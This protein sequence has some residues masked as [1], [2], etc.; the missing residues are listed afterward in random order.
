MWNQPEEYFIE[1][2]SNASME[3]FPDNTLSKFSNK[4][5]IPLE[6]DGEWVVGIQEIFYPIDLEP[7]ERKIQVQLF[8]SD[9]T[10]KLISDVS[11]NENDS[12]E[13]IV[14]K[15]NEA[16]HALFQKVT[17]DVVDHT[18][19]RDKRSIDK[20][21][22]RA[23]SKPTLPDGPLKN[24]LT[25]AE[26]NAITPEIMRNMEKAERLDLYDRISV[27]VPIIVDKLY[28][29]MEKYRAE[30]A[31]K[32]TEIAALHDN[33]QTFTSQ[34]DAVKTSKNEEHQKYKALKNDYDKKINDLNALN[35]N[36]NNLK[37]KITKLE[38][39]LQLKENE[40]QQ[41]K[42][43]ATAV[44]NKFTAKEKELLEAKYSFSQITQVQ[45]KRI[46]DLEESLQK[47]KNE[48]D[49]NMNTISGRHNTQVQ[50][51]QTEIDSL[52]NEKIKTDNENRV[53]IKKISDEF[54]ALQIAKNLVI[55][56]L[57]ETQ[58]EHEI[59]KMD[60]QRQLDDL[61][62]ETK[63]LKDEKAHLE[64]H[65]HL[66]SAEIED[67]KH[68]IQSLK[69]KEIDLASRLT[70]KELEI[71]R[72][73][74]EREDEKA[75]IESTRLALENKE[76][77]LVKRLTDLGIK[78]AK[79][80]T[81]NDNTNEFLNMPGLAYDNGKIIFYPGRSQGK[82]YIPYFSD[83]GFLNALGFDA[84]SY[85]QMISEF[86]AGK[87]SFSSNKRCNL[88]LRSHLMFINSDIVAEHFVG[89]KSARVMR[90]LPIKRAK[91]YEL[92][93]EKFLKPFYYPVRSNRIEDI[94]FLLTDEMGQNI[95]FN[96][97]RVLIGLHLKH[98]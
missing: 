58:R 25:L 11:L 51:M 83:T 33:L 15:I 87:A 76:N 14:S 21:E 39:K 54:D 85:L 56:Q 46:G 79:K 32:S 49:N 8:T 24:P 29:E 95:K 4:L 43:K 6:L 61:Q 1:V 42:E 36:I 17:G 34:L 82:N 96:S 2:V 12:P 75:E 47:K 10:D 16:L 53:K 68:E 69:T 26:V 62:N 52:K 67:M 81:N 44:S 18:Q 38:Q 30:A 72:K 91:E 66:K 80:D 88:N 31:N 27:G 92:V 97:G 90:V 64:H 98:V 19:N 93:H 89:N 13:V 71:K 63:T 7:E 23:F 77:L 59:M 41:A 65:L 73:I 78:K 22:N 37:E 35:T 84:A 28:K 20:S 86:S 45:A 55:R 94:N 57:K 48:S 3:D 50:Q 9:N 74:K 40:I 70:E 5:P 60:Y